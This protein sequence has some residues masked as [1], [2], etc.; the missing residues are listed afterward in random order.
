MSAVLPAIA[1]NGSVSHG[2]GSS[3]VNAPGSIAGDYAQLIAMG[4]DAFQRTGAKIFDM[5]AGALSLASPAQIGRI[6]QGTTVTADLVRQNQSLLNAIGAYCRANGIAIHVEALLTNDSLD[7]WTYQWLQPSVTANL[8][9]TAVEDV[10]EIAYAV[11]DTPEN[12]AAYAQREVAIVRQIVQ[13]YPTVKIGEWQGGAPATAVTDWW[14]AYNTAADAASLPRITYAVADTSWNAPWVTPTAAWQSWLVDLSQMVRANGMSLTVLLDGSDRGGSDRQWTAQSEQHAAMLATLGITADTLLV[15]SWGSAN[16]QSVSPVN[17]PTTI[18]NAAA[19]IAATYPLYS[20]RAITAADAIA[21]A[22]PPQ[23]IVATNTAAAVGSISLAWA[24]SDVAKGARVAVVITDQTGK[25]SARQSGAATVTGNGTNQ[26]ILNGGSADVAAALRSLT[27]IE[28]FAGPDSIDIET[29][30]INGRLSDRQVSLLAVPVV[31]ATGAQEFQFVP[32][33]PSQVWTAASASINA[34]HVI[35]SIDYTWNSPGISPGTGNYKLSK[36]VAIHEPLAEEEIAIVG[37]VA[38]ELLASPNPGSDASLPLNMD[39]FNLFAYNPYSHLSSVYVSSTTITYG[40]ISGELQST[41]DRLAPS[42]PLNPKY[43]TILSN[44]FA[45]GGTRITQ[46]NSGDNPN[47]LSSWSSGLSS[48]TTTYGSS[49]QILEQVFQGGASEPWFLLDNVFNPYTGLL[50]EQFQTVPPPAPFGNFVTGT[51]LLT[52]FNTGDNPNWDYTDWGSSAQVTVEWQDYYAKKVTAIS[53]VRTGLQNTDAYSSTGQ[54]SLTGPSSGG[55]VLI[56][57]NGTTTINAFGRDRIYA[58][59]GTTTI[60]TG[61]GGSTIYLSYGASSN[62]TIVSGGGDSIRV[63]HASLAIT[64]IGAA[65][66]QVYAQGNQVSIGDHSTIRVTGDYNAVTIRNSSTVTV[67]DS[68]NV[69]MVLG[70]GDT[71]TVGDAS[72]VTASGRFSTLNLNGAGDACQAGSN[73]TV[74]LNGTSGSGTAGT[75]TTAWF[76]G[77]GNRLDAGDRTTAWLIGSGNTLVAGDHSTIDLAGSGSSAVL[78]SY[79]VVW[80]YGTGASVRLQSSGII[81]QYGTNQVGVGGAGTSSWQAGTANQLTAGSNSTVNVVGNYGTASVGDASRITATGAHNTLNLNGANDSCQAGTNNTV[82][83]NGTSASASAGTDTTAWFWGSGN[84]L[85]AGDRTTAWL[86][87]SGNALTAG[88]HSTID[89]VGSASAAVLGS[90][91]VVWEYGTGASVRLQ[92]NGTINQYG[93]NQVGVGGTGTYSWQAGTANQLTAGNNSTVN[94]VGDHNTA[95]A[96]DASTIN[97]TGNHD[98]VSVGSMGMIFM[99]GSDETV[100]IRSTAVS[101]TITGFT[102]ADRDALDLNSALNGVLL[103]ND[104]SNLRNYVSAAGSGSDTVLTIHGSVATNTVIL[105]GAGTLSLSDMLAHN[106]LLLP[107]H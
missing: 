107:P 92:S 89:L 72:T 21:I 6:V 24:A 15:R 1:I 66:D 95:S 44:Y 86:V 43:A 5:D 78:G 79:C 94:V 47:W 17:E 100:L 48:V 22:A 81:N 12:Y 37:G 23:L 36:T 41:T 71:V 61:K 93:T 70:D 68:Q 97:I 25:L 106:A 69:L 40:E 56:G 102:L 91:C 98:L 77:D 84:R 26:L 87:G 30:G 74:Y 96:G 13:Y 64:N 85:V 58:G 59:L 38:R 16:P 50:W 4:A 57:C 67:P 8:P 19:A 60:A 33:S 45:T 105:R 104:L 3:A 39:R 65:S 73:N 54:L 32:A 49:N 35:S 76:W 82:V 75:D 62:V 42:T 83:L 63:G 11:A 52:Q 101:Q 88:D 55:G 20:H 99:H 9:I 80:E 7:D 51:Q 2:G 31:P 28:Q 53:P 14:S 103:N 90:D 34:A 27:V 46:L 10:R 18:S 29:F